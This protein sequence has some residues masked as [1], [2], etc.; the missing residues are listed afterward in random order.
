MGSGSTGCVWSIPS[1]RNGLLVSRG[2]QL[3]RGELMGLAGG[4]GNAVARRTVQRESH[5]GI[6][7][8]P[9]TDGDIHG[10]GVGAGAQYRADD[11]FAV[12]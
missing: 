5:C 3:F 2:A 12:E 4:L 11:F 1:G 10:P 6:Q 7:A 8:Y 9:V